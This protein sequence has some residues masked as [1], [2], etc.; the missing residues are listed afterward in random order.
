[1]GGDGSDE[2]ALKP[3][4]KNLFAWRSDSRVRTERLAMFP[5]I[6]AETPNLGARAEDRA[7]YAAVVGRSSALLSAI[8][9]GDAEAWRNASVTP[10]AAIIGM[11]QLYQDSTRGMSV[12]LHFEP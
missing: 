7:R 11:H 12:S 9:R 3:E 1:M 10:F 8:C 6:K 5:M 2:P 4:G